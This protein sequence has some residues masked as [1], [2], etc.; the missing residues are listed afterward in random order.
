MRKR[1]SRGR[2]ERCA[3]ATEDFTAKEAASH[4]RGACAS[5]ALMGDD[6]DRGAFARRSKEERRKEEQMQKAKE[7]GASY[8]G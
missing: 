7:K 5:P 4:P 1:R 6:V 3:K 8:D 2:D